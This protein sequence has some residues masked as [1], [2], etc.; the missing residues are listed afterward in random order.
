MTG[1]DSP[2]WRLLTD[3]RFKRQPDGSELAGWGN[4]AVSLDNSARTLCGAITCDA[5]HP[6]FLGASSRSN[7][8]AELTGFAEA[9]R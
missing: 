9:L 6:A 2:G 3:G 4:A 8:S 1:I 7:N 5:G